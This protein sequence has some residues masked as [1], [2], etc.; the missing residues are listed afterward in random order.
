MF[1]AHEVLS[2]LRDCE[3][4]YASPILDDE[5]KLIAVSYLLNTLPDASFAPH[6]SLITMVAEAVRRF[7][8]KGQNDAGRDTPAAPKTKGRKAKG[9][10]KSPEVD[11]PTEEEAGKA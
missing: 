1:T 11:D 5:Q 6:G 7:P 3:S 8:T 9:V 10:E 4:V 2:V